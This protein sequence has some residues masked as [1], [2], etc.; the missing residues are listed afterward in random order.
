MQEERSMRPNAVMALVVGLGLLIAAAWIGRRP[1][2]ILLTWPKVDAEARSGDVYWYYSVCSLCA[3]N[4]SQKAWAV[5]TL[6][7]IHVE[8]EGRAAA[9]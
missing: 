8:S 9:M 7:T 2:T 1:C 5:A 3:R 6:L 4:A